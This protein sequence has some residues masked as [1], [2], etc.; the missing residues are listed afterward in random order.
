M[1]KHILIA[2]SLWVCLAPDHT[3]AQIIDHGGLVPLGDILPD[4]SV[5]MDELDLQ[6]FIL[7]ITDREAYFELVSLN[8]EQDLIM[9][10][11]MNCDGELNFGDI[12]GLKRFYN[13]PDIHPCDPLVVPEP[14]SGLLWL[15]ALGSWIPLWRLARGE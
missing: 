15:S 10:A 1:I 9:A 13:D 4:G 6:A 3:S 11:D 5:H 14:S 2:F 7:A 12:H 8:N